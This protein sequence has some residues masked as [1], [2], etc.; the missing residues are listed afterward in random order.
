MNFEQQMQQA[1]QSF[2]VEAQELLASMEQGLLGLE[3][4]AYPEAVN[5]L[6]RAAHTIKGSAGLFGLDGIVRF[7]HHLESLLDQMRAGKVETREDVVNTLLDGRDLLA[8]LVDQVAQSGT[9]EA[10]TPAAQ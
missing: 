1:L 7:T 9:C 8:G 10:D 6:F 4:G 5:A 2:I 3:A